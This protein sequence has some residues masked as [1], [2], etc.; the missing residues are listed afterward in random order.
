MVSGDQLT[1]EDF[2]FL[3]SPQSDPRKRK[4]TLEDL[5]KELIERTLI[6]S[7]WNKTLTAKRMG[8]SRRA[9]YEKALRLGISLNPAGRH[10]RA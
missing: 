2:A 6:E 8:I 5:E 9:L 10:S 1:A 3:F 4:G 7:N